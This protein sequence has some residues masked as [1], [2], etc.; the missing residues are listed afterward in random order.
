MT[1]M[2]LVLSWLGR[3]R[4]FC[5][6]FPGKYILLFVHLYQLLSLLSTIAKTC[7]RSNRQFQKVQ[8]VGPDSFWACSEASVMVLVY[9]VADSS[10]SVRG[11]C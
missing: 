2:V 8:A 4:T 1:V 9:V 5:L 3:P 7:G 10:S 11:T 6:P